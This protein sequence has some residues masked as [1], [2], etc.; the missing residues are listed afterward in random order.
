MTVLVH[1]LGGGL[2][3]ISGFV[4]LAAAKGARLHRASGRLFVYAMVALTSTGITMAAF[5]GDVGSVIGGLL[6]AYLVIT[7]LTT[8]RPVTAVSRTLDLALMLLALAAGMTSAMFGFEAIAAP[9]GTIHGIPAAVF[10]IFAAAF[11][12][13]STGDLRVMRSGAPRGAPRLVRHL[14]RMCMA[15]WIATAS[16]FLGPRWRVAKILPASLISTPVL[17][18][19]V[20]LVIGAM[21]YWL[22]RVRVRRT[23]RGIGIVGAPEAI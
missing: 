3:I 12:L 7:A 8:V 10:F 2:G 20:L 16:F 6:A 5:S 19:P 13:G 15:L 14:W 22:W 1:L 4:A 23:Y 21:V 9:K 18:I 11:L 17:A